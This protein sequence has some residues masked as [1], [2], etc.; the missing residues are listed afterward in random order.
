MGSY[1]VI[2][3]CVLCIIYLD[4]DFIYCEIIHA[5]PKTSYTF[6]NL[7]HPF[8]GLK[9]KLG[10]I[11]PFFLGGGIYQSKHV[12]LAIYNFLEFNFG[13]RSISLGCFRI[14]LVHQADWCGSPMFPDGADRARVMVFNEMGLVEFLWM[15]SFTSPHDRR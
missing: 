11:S 4:I 8:A 3:S 2:H 1:Q 14:R 7:I 15:A 10:T 6:F 5:I 9:F 12:Q 13:L